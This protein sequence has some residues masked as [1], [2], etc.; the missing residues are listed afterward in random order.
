MKHGILLLNFGHPSAQE[1]H[2][3]IIF[4]HLFRPALSD[5]PLFKF[6]NLFLETDPAISRPCTREKIQNESGGSPLN[7]WGDLRSV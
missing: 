6:F 5:G 1:M 3:N 7:K 4:Q 2:I